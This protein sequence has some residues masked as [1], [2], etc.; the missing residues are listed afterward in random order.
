MESMLRRC[1][2]EKERYKNPNYKDVTVCKEWLCFQNFAEWWHDNYYEIEGEQM[3][4]DKDILHKGNKVYNPDNCIFAPQS[5]N[6][7]F[8]R[9]IPRENLP[10]GVSYDKKRN[11]YRAHCCVKRKLIA[12]G[13]KYNTPQDAFYLGY[14]P[15][16]EAYIRQV[17]NEYKHQIPKRL[18][19][20]MMNWNIEITD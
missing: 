19:D 6:I 15:F 11:K 17:A 12:I 10:A 1:Y 18:Y 3:Q 4:L 2:S 13:N 20:A 14:K 5:I 7:L 8:T 9:H 16:K